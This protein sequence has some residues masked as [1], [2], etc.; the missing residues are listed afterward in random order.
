M[1]INPNRDHARINQYVDKTFEGKVSFFPRFFEKIRFEHFRHI[2]NAELMFKNP[3]TVISGTNRSGKT[4]FLMAIACSHYNFTRRKVENGNVVRAKWSDVMRFT[5]K[6]TQSHDWTYYVTYREK[7]VVVADKRGQR[8]VNT[9]K[10]NGV[11]KKEGQIGH[12]LYAGDSS[13]R[14]VCFI[15]MN[16]I[17]PG[18]HLSNSY[19]QK[20]RFSA[21]KQLTKGAE[22]EEYLSY[23]FEKNITVKLISKAGD[24]FVYE[25]N[26]NGNYSSFNTASGEDA[27]LNML[28]DILAMPNES[29]VLI[30]EIE[31]GLHPKLQRR[32]M[33]VIFRIARKNK[34]QFILTTHSY[35][36]MD[37]VEQSSRIFIDIR[38]GI[39]E[40]KQ[41]ITTEEV[42]TR[43]DSER[44]PRASVYVED[45]ISEA[46]VRKA[47]SMLNVEYPGF[48][49]LVC[50]V[51]VGPAN[52][53]YDYFKNRQRLADRDRFHRISLCILDGDKRNEK[54]RNGD[55]QFSP[56]ADLFFIHSNMPPEEMLLNIYLDNYPNT[57]L[58]HYRHGENPHVLA[59]KMVEFDV[60]ATESE[61]LELWLSA[62]EASP[63]GI[64]Y[65]EEL[66]TFLRR[67]LI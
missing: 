16:R 1:A 57:D 52:M 23:V 19:F 63:G 60:A 9:K 13:G 64:T 41:D 50:V 15:D 10:W 55:L 61:A 51:P 62:F 31:I 66:K 56:E 4:S 58:E 22:I 27:V 7:K 49:R 40:V 3:V 18:R 20:A 6:D 36:I 65:Y 47:V 21:S 14:H 11:A 26:A 34:I 59:K 46:I 29:L 38:N 35:A 67:I 44:F 28:V 48:A 12:P 17:S 24:G 33:D 8:K 54:N 39:V 43:I 42:L 45:D 5:S 30:D 37:S 2:D 25:L 53:T 32:L